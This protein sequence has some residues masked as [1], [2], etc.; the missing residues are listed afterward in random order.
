MGIK[1]FIVSGKWIF[2]LIEQMGH[3]GIDVRLISSQLAR[4]ITIAEKYNIDS[5]R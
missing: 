3:H 1:K 5:I 2:S 4:R